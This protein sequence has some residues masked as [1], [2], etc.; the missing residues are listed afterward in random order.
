M[1]QTGDDFIAS[2][3]TRYD[4]AIDGFLER[5]DRL[6]VTGTEGAGKST[7]LAQI[8]VMAAAGVHPWTLE[9]VAP[10]NVGVIDME[11]SSRLLARRFAGLKAS[12]AHYQR[13]RGLP[14]PWEPTRF[15]IKSKPEGIDL[16]QRAD[17]RWLLERCLTNE[18]DLLIIGPLYRMFSGTAARGDVG[19]EDMARHV[20]AAL[21]EV[22]HQAGVTLVMETHA[23]HG[24]TS[25]RD[26]RP[27]GSSVW[28][29][30]PEFGVGISH[31]ADA[32]PR[33]YQLGHWRDPRDQRTWPAAL[34]KHG[35]PWPWTPV[36]NARDL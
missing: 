6:L 12:L 3:D 26:L 15:R 32:P 10:L 1:M 14:E 19:G 7:L 20:T 27:F 35:S 36:M 28:L 13:H 17:R 23:P 4:W 16:T 11:N 22:R 29:R 8:A 21:D 2:T 25:T 31:K 9:H 34:L 18:T 33:E 24:A 30:W 5:Q